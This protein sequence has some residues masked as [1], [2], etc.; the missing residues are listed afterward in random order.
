MTAQLIYSIEPTVLLVEKHEG[1]GLL[2]FHKTSRLELIDSYQGT[3]KHWLRHL[4]KHGNNVKTIWV[5]E[6]FTDSSIVDVALNFSHYHDIV[7]SSLWANLIPENGLDGRPPGITVDGMGENIRKTMLDS[8]WKATVGVELH[9]KR[10][11]NTDWESR[12]KDQSNTLNDSEWKATI[13]VRKI[14]LYQQTIN[15][16]E[17]RSTVGVERTRKRLEKTDFKKRNEKDRQKKYS[18]HKR[19]IVM[20]IKDIAEKH[21][22]K[23]G[24]GWWQKSDDKLEVLLQQLKKEY[25]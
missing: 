11:Q 10:V 1:T 23:L 3:G 4:K 17:W 24:S 14:R 16:P 8:E 7:E 21:K 13:G 20:T 18:L 15:D 2:Y 25:K 12:N 5:S 22:I 6:V 9:R 19:P